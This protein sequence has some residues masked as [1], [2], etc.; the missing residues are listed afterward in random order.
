MN[1][2][3][4]HTES[5]RQKDRTWLCEWSENVQIICTLR[6]SW[7]SF[8]GPTAEVLPVSRASRRETSGLP[9]HFLFGISSAT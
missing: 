8:T 4:M 5:S 7:A 2:E 9:L 6:F 3:M 1:L